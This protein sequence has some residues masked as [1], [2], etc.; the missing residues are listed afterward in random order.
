[1]NLILITIRIMMTI[2]HA[3]C[4]YDHGYDNEYDYD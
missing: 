3:F 2:D 4:N 1:M